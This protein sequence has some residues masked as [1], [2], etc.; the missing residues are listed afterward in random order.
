MVAGGAGAGRPSAR[1]GRHHATG[2]AGHRPRRAP[3]RP[4]PDRQAHPLPGVMPP[5]TLPTSVQPADSSS[6]VIDADRLPDGA[7]DEDRPVARDLRRAAGELRHR[8]EQR[9]LDADGRELVAFADVEQDRGPDGVAAPDV[10]VQRVTAGMAAGGSWGR[11]PPDSGRVGGA[12]GVGEPRVDG[13]RAAR[14]RP[15]PRRARPRWRWRG[16][17]GRR[18]GS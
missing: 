5:A 15:R 18:P 9:A 17:R 1:S 8:D 12:G 11:D 3:T 13:V 14:P 7:H 16:G 10:G 6:P 2:P 4:A